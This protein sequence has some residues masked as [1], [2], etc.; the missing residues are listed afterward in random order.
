MNFARPMNSGSSKV[1]LVGAYP[2]PIGGNSIHIERLFRRLRDS[3]HDVGVLDYT[4]GAKPEAPERVQVLPRSPLAM[5]VNLGQLSRRLPADTLMHFH[6][7]ALARF[8]WIAPFLLALFRVH[9]KVVT[10]HSG[11]FVSGARTIPRPYLRWLFGRFHRVITVHPALG[12][13]LESVGVSRE[14]LRVI[15]AFL[16]ATPDATL[17][18]SSIRG[19]IEGKTVIVTSGDLTPIYQYGPLL[20]G[21]ERIGTREHLFVFAFYGQSDPAYEASVLGRLQRLPN[22][23]ILR[24][25]PADTFVSILSIAN[26]YVRLTTTDGDS[27]AVREALALGKAVFA[28]NCVERPDGCET[29]ALGDSAALLQLIRGYRRDSGSHPPDVDLTNFHQILCAYAEARQEAAMGCVRAPHARP[30]LRPTAW[31]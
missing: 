31:S 3:D 5:L 9:P 20:D 21:I 16:P 23:L 26:V 17:V 7:S 24:D 4:G 28:S 22:V 12:R 8:K 29:F 19:K 13:F 15:P 18:P 2:P 14:R 1:L 6:L 25:T 27:V 10:I 11:R 30:D